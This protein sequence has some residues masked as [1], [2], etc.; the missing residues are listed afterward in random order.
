MSFLYIIGC[1]AFTVYGQII[2]KWRVQS[3]GPLPEGAHEKAIYLCKVIIDPFVLSGF[4]AAFIASLFWIAAMTRFELSFAYPFMSLAF[5]LVLAISV[6][7]F[8]ESMNWYK[9][10]GTSLIIM[11]LSITYLGPQT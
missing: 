7:F 5:V 4:A 8:N 2:L 10:A 9:L 6:L 1:V 11:G 3:F